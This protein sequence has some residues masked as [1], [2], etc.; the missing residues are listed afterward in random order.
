MH[1]GL[2]TTRGHRHRQ[3]EMDECKNRKMLAGG[4]YKA[5]PYLGANY[6]SILK[7]SSLNP[8][9]DLFTDLLDIEESVKVRRCE[10]W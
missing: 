5:I 3:P 7:A 6:L 10:G 2:S 8:Q 4:N 1:A 9:E